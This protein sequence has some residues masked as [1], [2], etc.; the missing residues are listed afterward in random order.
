MCEAPDESAPNAEQLPRSFIPRDQGHFDTL[1]GLLEVGDEALAVAAW[2]L[3]QMLATNTTLYRRVLTLDIARS[4]GS[5]AVDWSKF[6]DRSSAYRL[7]YTIQ[8]VQAVLEDG[9]G[10]PA[11]VSIINAGDF[12]GGQR[13]EP[14]QEVGEVTL[15]ENELEAAAS[16]APPLQR[17]TSSVTSP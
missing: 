9:E 6:F 13:V 16:G 1:I 7:I 8:I 12:P 4:P 10:G 11:Q 3:I 14:S 2:E 17:K 5:L 15:D